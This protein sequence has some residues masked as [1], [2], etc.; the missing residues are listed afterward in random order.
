MSLFFYCFSQLEAKWGT[1]SLRR[2]STTSFSHQT[3]VPLAPKS[4]GTF[5][6]Q[7]WFLQT[8]KVCM[9]PLRCGHQLS[10]PVK[11][12]CSS[13]DPVSLSRLL[14]AALLLLFKRQSVET[15]GSYLGISCFLLS[16]RWCCFPLLKIFSLLLGTVKALWH[17]A[18]LLVLMCTF[19]C[20]TSI[21]N[22]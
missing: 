15:D 12:W 16:L 7:P 11:P 5:A 13:L 20:T 22:Y 14:Q 21:L 9:D 10:E 3:N 8:S 1:V 2:T 6:L 18:A 17:L 19:L 4:R